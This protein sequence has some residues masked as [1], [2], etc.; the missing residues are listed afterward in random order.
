VA[1]V[2][3]MV[4][5]GRGAQKAENDRLQSLGTTQLSVRGSRVFRGGVA[6]SSDRARLEVDDA[7]ALQQQ[8]TSFAAVQ[9]EMSRQLRVQYQHHTTS[10]DITGTTPNSAGVQKFGVAAGR[11]FDA[12]D[13]AGRKRVAVLGATTAE[14]LN[15]GDP[16]G[17]VGES[18]RIRGIQFEVI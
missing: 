3:T 6:S 1:A 18:I 9:P 14:E 15:P 7:V 2:I 5:L 4:A 10:P 8:G 16:N 13:D 12:A 11:V 17:L